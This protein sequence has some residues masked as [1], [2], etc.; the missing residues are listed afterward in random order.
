MRTGLLDT[1]TQ[2]RRG[3]TLKLAK[4]HAS[5]RAAITPAFAAITPAFAASPGAMCGTMSSGPDIPI[6]EAANAAS[7]HSGESVLPSPTMSE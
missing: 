7:A 2:K 1:G 3:P 5:P 6:A 4:H